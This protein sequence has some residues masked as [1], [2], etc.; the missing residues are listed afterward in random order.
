VTLLTE[1]PLTELEAQFPPPP[2]GPVGTPWQRGAKRALDVAVGSGVLLV[3]VPLLVACVI[4][5]RLDSR[6]PAV[7]RQPRVGRDGRLFTIFKLRTMVADAEAR[8][9]E[10]L[11]RN[12]MDGP[13]FK[14]AA[15]PRITR[16]GRILRK[17]S[18]DELPQLVN[19]L[20]GDMSLVGPRP[21]LPRE[22]ET[23]APELH[24][25]LR[26]RPGITGL[27]QV[28]GRSDS[29]FEDYVRY[30]LE[31]VDSWSVRRDLAIL[32]RTVPRVVLGRGAS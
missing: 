21:A 8:R 13:L 23:W 7:F 14:I 19:V 3:L 22:A 17:L 1:S 12:E 25:R 30:D 27:W 4:A 10:L 31:Y 32:A 5:V 2:V 6:G 15:D 20:R 28:S 24:E 9:A 11:D 16:V 18:I 26:V 29:S